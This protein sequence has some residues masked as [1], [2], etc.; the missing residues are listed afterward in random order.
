MCEILRFCDF[1]VVLSSPV[2]SWLYFFC[3]QLRQRR[4]PERILTVY[5]SNDSLLE[6]RR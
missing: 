5:G 6:M 2:L 3:S 4:T 1:F